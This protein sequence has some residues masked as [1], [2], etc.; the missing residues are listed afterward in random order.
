MFAEQKGCLQS[1]RSSAGETGNPQEK[2]ELLIE[3][4]MNQSESQR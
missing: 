4:I 2:L 1:P 3:F